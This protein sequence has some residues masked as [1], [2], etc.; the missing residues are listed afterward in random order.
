MI[1]YEYLNRKPGKINR[2]LSV[3]F[4]FQ[5]AYFYFRKFAYAKL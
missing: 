1:S 5:R 2:I 3:N 4:K